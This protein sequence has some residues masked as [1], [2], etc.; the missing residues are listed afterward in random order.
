MEP[1]IERKKELLKSLAHL[2]LTLA[3]KRKLFYELNKKQRSQILT[4]INHLCDS[5]EN[6]SDAIFDINH[7]ILYR[8]KKMT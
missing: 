6:I 1:L 5:I 3:E 4:E 2:R 8:R 7:F